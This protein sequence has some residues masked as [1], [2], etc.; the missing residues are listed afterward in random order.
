MPKVSIIIPNYNYAGYLPRRLHSI[1]EQTYQDVEIIFVD[2]CSTD[3]SLE[4]A[5]EQLSGHQVEYILNN[6]NSGSPFKSWNKGVQR[7]RGEYLWLAEADDWADPRF[8]AETSRMMEEHPQLGLVYCSSKTVDQQDNILG[9]TIS[10]TD[11]FDTELWRHNFT[12]DG[13]R[14][15][16]NY[17]IYRNIIHNASAVLI[18]RTSWDRAG[19][20]DG[21][22]R[23]TGDWLQWVKI[24]EHADI[25]YIARPL[26]FFRSHPQ[27]AREQV[28]RDYSDVPEMYQV[29]HYI[30]QHFMPPAE[31]KSQAFEKLFL[32][33]MARRPGISYFFHRQNLKRLFR[34]YQQ[35]RQLDPDILQRLLRFTTASSQRK[36]KRLWEHSRKRR[37]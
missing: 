6:Q 22:M 34:I 24:L 12:M 11:D 15:C 7:A 37:L 3:K 13:A 16:L 31:L 2:D 1:L 30:T 32:A 26:N 14:F 27:C 33:C 36:L 23:L 21:S 5:K 29:L 25:G 8:L 19:Q 10:L 9:E 17:L 4:V 28:I 18:R 35:V 20:A